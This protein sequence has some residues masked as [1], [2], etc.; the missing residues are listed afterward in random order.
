MSVVSVGVEGRSPIPPNSPFPPSPGSNLSTN[1]S[2]AWKTSFRVTV[3]LPD[4]DSVELRP[5]SKRKINFVI[6]FNALCTIFVLRATM[7]V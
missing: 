2:K 7:S 3:M 1:S 6:L 5:V 4:C